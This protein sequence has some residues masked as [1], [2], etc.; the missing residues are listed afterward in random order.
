[1]NLARLTEI[2]GSAK[3]DGRNQRA[4]QTR[5]EI[6]AA[7]REFMVA[8]EFAPSAARVAA[9]A[10]R[11]IRTIFEH[12]GDTES[13]HAAALGDETTRRAVLTLACDSDTS[14]LDWP[15]ELQD[16]VLH[17]ILYRRPIVRAEA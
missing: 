11:S 8:G 2:T 17:A 12:F 5:A 7:C 15:A 10:D 13:M 1:M 3:Y 6:L 16:A 14:C 4:P 9:R